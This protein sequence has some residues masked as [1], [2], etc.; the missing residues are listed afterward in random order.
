MIMLFQF[1][2]GGWLAEFV[3]VLKGQTSENPLG[4]VEETNKNGWSPKRWDK[5][6]D[7]DHISNGLKD[8]DGSDIDDDSEYN[9]DFLNSDNND[10]ITDNDNFFDKGMDKSADWDSDY[11]SDR[12]DVIITKDIS[13]CFLIQADRAEWPVQQDCDVNKFDKFGEVIQK[14]KAF[15]YKNIC[16]WIIKNLQKGEWNVLIMKIH[17][18]HYKGVDK[19]PKLYIIFKDVYSSFS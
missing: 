12:I 18:W 19:K 4:V 10:A 3:H 15:C 14:T 5:H 6:D 11:S 17:L 1:Y 9:H 2:I 16:F 7:N 8:N 13:D